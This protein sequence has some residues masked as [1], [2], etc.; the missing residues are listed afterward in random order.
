GGALARGA[1]VRWLAARGGAA[2]G[3][4]AVVPV[5]TAAGICRELDGLPLAIELAAARMSVLSVEEIAARLADRFRLLARRR[6]VGEARHQTLKAAIGWG[7]DLLS[8]DER[9]VF[10]GLSVVAAGSTL[11]AGA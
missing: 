8:E 11:A 1:A 3:P 4:G 7:Y 5:E 9:R 10:G 6:P 2:A